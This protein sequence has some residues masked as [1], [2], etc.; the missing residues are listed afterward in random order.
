MSW[1]D[2]WRALSARIQGL[3]DAGMFFFSAQHTSSAD[4]R[5]VKRK[6]LLRTAEKIINDLAGFKDNCVSILP[7][8]AYDCIDRLINDVA[9][10]IRLRP[11]TWQAVSGDCQF[12]LTSLA[13]FRSEFDYIVSDNQAVVRRITERAFIHLQ[14]SIVADLVVRDKWEKAFNEREDRCEQLGAVHLLSHGIWAFKINAQGGRTDLVM[15]EPLPNFSQIESA[16]DG[17]VLTEW[18]L[19]RAETNLTNKIESA[20]RQA[21][22]YSTGVLGGIELANYRYLVMVSEHSMKMPDDDVVDTIR[23]RHINIAVVPQTPSVTAKND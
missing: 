8:P 21:G 19:V 17:L 18:K 16:A 20:R 4:D 2:E 3:L 10:M 11:D 6:I 5:E 12:A 23:Y 14:R 22:I 9:E 7:T 1:L 13:A 15:N